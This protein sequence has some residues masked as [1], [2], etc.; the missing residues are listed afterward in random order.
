MYPD[1]ALLHVRERRTIYW[2]HFGLASNGDYSVK[3]LQKLRQYE[4]SGFEPG[5]DLLFSVEADNMP[6]DVKGL[7][8][9]SRKNL[10]G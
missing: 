4:S 5:R 3:A 6:L 8:E 9:K 10:L 2:E 7:E 1:F